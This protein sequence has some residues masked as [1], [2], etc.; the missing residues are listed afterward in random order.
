MSSGGIQPSGTQEIVPC[1]QESPV[2]SV[3][4]CCFNRNVRMAGTGRVFWR[5]IW[6][7]SRLRSCVSDQT[8]ASNY[9]EAE[10]PAYSCCSYP[11]PCAHGSLRRV[12]QASLDALDASSPSRWNLHRVGWCLRQARNTELLLGLTWLFDF[13]RRIEQHR[14]RLSH[15]HPSYH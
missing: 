6:P 4:R 1:R 9:S 5:C 14:L 8:M 13:S 11:F 10:L 7:W 15:W 12:W 3:T 2:A